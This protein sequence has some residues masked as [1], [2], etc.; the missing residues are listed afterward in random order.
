MSEF[1]DRLRELADAMDRYDELPDEGERQAWHRACAV[2][3]IVIGRGL[4]RSAGG[5][6]REREQHVVRRILD[7][8]GVKR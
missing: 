3:L 6:H 8:A 7:R 2:E 4:W 5:E 1:S